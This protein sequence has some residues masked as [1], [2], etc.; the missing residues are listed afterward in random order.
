MGQNGTGDRNFG[1]MGHIADR[2]EREFGKKWEI[3]GRGE[4]ISVPF[5]PKGTSHSP[6]QVR[7]SRIIALY[8]L[9]SH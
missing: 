2:T 6:Q 7:L 4:K 5:F 3:V 9:C 1:H 8:P